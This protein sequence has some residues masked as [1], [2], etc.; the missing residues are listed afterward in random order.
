MKKSAKKGPHGKEENKEMKG[1]KYMGGPKEEKMEMKGMKMPMK[2][3]CGG[4]V[5]KKR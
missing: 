4:A 2:M 3:A 5:K 1:G